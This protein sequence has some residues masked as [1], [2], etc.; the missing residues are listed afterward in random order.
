MTEFHLW[1]LIALYRARLPTDD[2]QRSLRF[3]DRAVARAIRSQTPSAHNLLQA[4]RGWRT[5]C[6][7]AQVLKQRDAST[8]YRSALAP[9]RSLALG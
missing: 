2:L 8:L 6:Q 5:V 7:A 3:S 1:Q 9:A 4:K